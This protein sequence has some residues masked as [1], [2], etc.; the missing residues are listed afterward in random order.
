MN[1]CCSSDSDQS[2][3]AEKLARCPASTCQELKYPQVPHRTVLHHIKTPWESSVIPQVYYFCQN[4]NCDVVYFGEDH[5]AITKEQLRTKVGIKESD[6]NALICY[7]FGVSNRVAKT[8][9]QVKKY[10]IEQTKNGTCSCSTF[11]PSGKCCLKD[12]P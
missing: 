8:N 1:D 10:V 9:D 6:E 12:F 5:S 7:C 11:N 2:D 4:K 3:K